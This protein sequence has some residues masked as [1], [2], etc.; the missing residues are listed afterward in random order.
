LRC[1]VIIQNAP[2]P[3]PGTAVITV[4]GLS[5]SFMNQLTIAGLLFD[6]RENKIVIEAGDSVSGLAQI[7]AGTIWQAY[8]QASQPDM[9]FIM[10]ANPANSLQLVPFAPTSFKGTV[11]GAAVLN[12]I[13]QKNGLT[14]ENNGGVSAVLSNPYFYGSAWDQIK[15]CVD[16]INC[17]GHLDINKSNFAIWP[18]KGNRGNTSIP[19]FSPGTGMIGYPEF[20]QAQITVRS[21]F[22]TSV[23]ILPGHRFQVKSQFTAANGFWT[24]DT[25]V[26]THISAGMPDGPWEIVVVGNRIP[27]QSG[28]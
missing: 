9:A 27:G 2:T 25:R 16:A 3:F 21:L 28:S 11:D 26:E 22:D 12:Q 18:K 23:T 7:Y 13:A 20:Q 4:W 1:Q 10:L 6:G 15:A 8:P 14:L 5:L 24:A 17:Y 19:M